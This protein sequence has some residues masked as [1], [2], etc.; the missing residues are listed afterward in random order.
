MENVGENP[1]ET[2]R[3]A[4][5]VDDRRGSVGRTFFMKPV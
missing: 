1:T 3:T 5:Y 2:E 4:E